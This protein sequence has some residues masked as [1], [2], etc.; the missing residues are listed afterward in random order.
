[1]GTLHKIVI[2][3]KRELSLGSERAARDLLFWLPGEKQ[4]LRSRFLALARAR[5]LRMTILENLLRHG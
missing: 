3:S 5:S 1:M 4:V 2:P